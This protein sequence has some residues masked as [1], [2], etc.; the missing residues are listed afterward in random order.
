MRGIVLA[1]IATL[2]LTGCS[3]TNTDLLGNTDARTDTRIDA[4]TDGVM[5]FEPVDGATLTA[6]DDISP[7]SEGIQI[8]VR[9]EVTGSY[10]CEIAEL[11]V[12]DDA[13]HTRQYSIPTDGLDAFDFSP[14]SLD[15]SSYTLQ[16]T[17]EHGEV[18]SN[19]IH[20]DVE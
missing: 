2:F 3:C 10:N 7:S 5:C 4:G 17:C 20:V 9:C 12:E 8:T 18:E 1:A 11:T 13:G 15:T 6:A 16:V 19:V 14:V